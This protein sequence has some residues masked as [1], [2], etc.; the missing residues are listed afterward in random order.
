MQYTAMLDREAEEQPHR[1]RRVSGTD[2]EAFAL[3]G[4]ERPRP[5]YLRTYERLREAIIDGRLVPGQRLVENEVARMLNV[6]RTP[7]R[8]ALR[9]LEQDGLV[10]IVEGYAEVYLPTPADV[11]ALYSCRAAVEGMAAY[12]AVLNATEA[13]LAALDGIHGR[14]VAA[15]ERGD[16]RAC[17]DINTEFHDRIIDTARNPWLTKMHDMLRVHALLMRYYNL[18]QHTRRD[19]TVPQHA[20]ILE[21]MHAKD[22]DRARLA[23]EEHIIANRDAAVANLP[24]ARWPQPGDPPPRSEGSEA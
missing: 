23:M 2:A 21:A 6:S 24:G 9:K 7:V 16:T 12:F 20:A 18:H 5:L 17:L 19:L 14:L 10:Q 15:F 11:F 13:D 3:A 8:E 4:L 22:P 1:E